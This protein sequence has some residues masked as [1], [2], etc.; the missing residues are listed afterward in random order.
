MV[1]DV[2]LYM[3]FVGSGLATG[4]GAIVFI[5]LKIYKRSKN[6]ELKLQKRKA[7]V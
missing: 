3:F 5:G 4:V 7:V 6:K 2:F 1:V